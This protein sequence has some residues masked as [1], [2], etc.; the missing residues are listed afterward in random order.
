MSDSMYES[1]HSRAFGPFGLMNVTSKKIYMIVNFASE[2]D[3]LQ[4]LCL[5]NGEPPAKLHCNSSP[6]FQFIIG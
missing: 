2:K 3:N 4:R 5:P 6:V 1:T